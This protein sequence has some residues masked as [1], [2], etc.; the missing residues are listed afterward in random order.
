[1]VKSFE[2]PL[3][4]RQLFLDFKGVESRENLNHTLHQ[5]EKK[6]PVIEPEE[7]G[8]I[9]TRSAPSWVPGCVPPIL[10]GI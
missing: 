8:A 10:R 7:A 9:Q 1:M 2:I 4:D 5:P 6:G 3:G